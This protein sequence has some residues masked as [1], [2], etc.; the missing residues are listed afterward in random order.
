VADVALIAQAV[1]TTPEGYTVPGS[2]EIIL[3]SVTAS[4]DGTGAG[5]SFIPTLQIIAP[6]GSVVASCPVSTTLAAGALADVSWFP[7]VG[8]ASSGGGG[9]STRDLYFRFA[10]G[11]FQLPTGIAGEFSLDYAATISQ[12]TLLAD[13]TG[14]AVVDIWKTAFGSYPPTVAN[15]ITGSAL[16]TLTSALAAKSSTLT[17]W[18][19]SISAGDTFRVNLN[20]VASL[21]RLTLMLEITG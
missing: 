6:N 9:S 3:K 10:N 14:S 5:G 18:T 2:Q 20:S 15:T 1:T 21:T 16:P 7:R 12:W 8:G 4:Y 13:Q 17:G 11:G 19:T